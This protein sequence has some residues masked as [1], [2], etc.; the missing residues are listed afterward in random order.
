M[1][2]RNQIQNPSTHPFSVRAHGQ[3]ALNIWELENAAGTVVFSVDA[4]GAVTAAST[5]TSDP[6]VEVVADDGAIGNVE[7]VV[8]LTKAGAIAATLAA[9]TDVTDDGKRLTIIS[10]T[11]QTHTVTQTDPGFNSGST[12]SDVATW[13]GAIGDSME[14]VAY[15][16]VWHAV[17]LTNVTLG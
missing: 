9:P 12:G 8:L 2:R 15:G 13:G 16:A 6:L 5:V 11:A 4:N 17:N 14:I 7:G 3:E 1:V 10:T